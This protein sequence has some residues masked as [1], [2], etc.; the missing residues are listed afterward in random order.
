MPGLAD[1]GR[2]D[3]LSLFIRLLVTTLVPTVV[4][5]ALRSVWPAARRFAVTWK[6]QLSM[7]A[8]VCL[9]T[10]I[11]QSLST[12]RPA[13]IWQ[14]FVSLVYIVLLSIAQ[15]LI[16]YAIS[17]SACT[18]MKLSPTET[19]AVAVMA[20]QKSAPIAVAVAAS[21]A[22]NGEQFG[23]LVVPMIINQLVQV[24]SSS[25][26][27]GAF[28]GRNKAWNAAEKEKKQGN[29]AKG[30][31]GGEEEELDRSRAEAPSML[32]RAAV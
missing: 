20:S 13:L 2:I 21:V 22:A 12:A 32:G 6:K 8:T 31:A 1:G 25:A 17:L 16:H 26:V 23:L 18:F 9:A 30:N 24:F 11:W 3:V 7:S 15:H 4:G 5:C 29:A 10:I 28:R 14:P 27:S 19:T